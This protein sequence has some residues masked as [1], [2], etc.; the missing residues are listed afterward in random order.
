MEKRWFSIFAARRILVAPNYKRYVRMLNSLGR[1]EKKQP[2]Q[3]RREEEPSVAQATA[4]PKQR[5]KISKKSYRRKFWSIL[6]KAGEKFGRGGTWKG[7][8]SS[9]PAR[10]A[11]RNYARVGKS[12][13]SGVKSELKSMGLLT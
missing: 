2:R 3:R 12:V 8:N 6:K 1:Q 10:V 13:P 9:H 4:Q 11:Y 7:L 5:K